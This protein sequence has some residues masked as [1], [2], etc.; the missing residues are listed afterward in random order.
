METEIHGLVAR[1]NVKNPAWSVDGNSTE[2]A[3]KEKG[4]SDEGQVDFTFV[5]AVPQVLAG[6]PSER[7]SK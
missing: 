3:G 1:L 4:P 7:S 5:L 2:R 6:R